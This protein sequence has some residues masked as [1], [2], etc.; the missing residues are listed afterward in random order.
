VLVLYA[1][2]HGAP[3]G[4]VYH[5]GDEGFGLLSPGRLGNLLDELGIKNRLLI[6]SS[7]YSGTFVPRLANDD[8]AVI[9][10]SAHDRTSFGCAAEN[11]WTFFGDAMINHAMRAPQPLAAAFA[12]ANATIAGWERQYRI[13]PSQ[14][15]ISVGEGAARWLG[16]LERRIPPG[17]THPV[18][19]PAT[20]T[21]P[22]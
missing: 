6:L 12:E 15:E 18:G 11:D 4:I 9:T 16:A 13:M 7:C 3:T 1:T 10:A 17:A 5:D 19:R 20:E 22:R 8:S 2:S 14:P 21:T